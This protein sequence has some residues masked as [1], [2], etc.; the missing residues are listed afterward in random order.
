M[1]SQ[2]V[3]CVAEKLK[4]AALII[5]TALM[6]LAPSSLHAQDEPSTYT[7]RLAFVWG[8]LVTNDKIQASI[9]SAQLLTEAGETVPVEITSELLS[10]GGMAALQGALVEIQGQINAAGA[11][12]AHAIQRRV[13]VSGTDSTARTPIYGSH[14]WIVLLCQGAGAAVIHENPV[15]YYNELMGSQPYAVD[16]F[17]REV[18]YGKANV[19]GSRSA[20]WFDLPEPAAAYQDGPDYDRSLIADKAAIDCTRAADPSVDFTPYDGIVLIVPLPPVPDGPSA[21]WFFG[22]LA[23]L[24]LD[25]KYRVIRT[26]WMPM[27]IAGPDTRDGTDAH[28]IL[29]EMGHGF[30]LPHSSG[31]YGNVYDSKWD[32]MSMSGAGNCYPP[33]ETFK[34]GCPSQHTIAVHK[35]WLGWLD[36]D[37]LLT[38]AE[39][40][41]S[42]VLLNRLALPAKP[43]VLMIKAP[44]A[45]GTRYYTVEARQLSGYDKALATEAVIIHEINPSRKAQPAQVVDPDG[46]GDPN[47]EGAQWQPGERFDGEGGFTLCVKGRTPEGYIV[48]A[49]RKGPVNCTFKPDLSPSRYSTDM[50]YPTAGQTVTIEIELV[51]YQ[52]AGIQRRSHDHH[53][54]RNH[55][56]YRYG[57]DDSR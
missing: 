17:W 14:P 5:V 28:I 38:V 16:H 41:A 46:N 49:G 53:S 25:G 34:Y 32:M 21:T 7:G 48:A 56:Y 11:I 29:H 13:G 10:A 57:L 54:Q 24:K 19:L 42:E 33:D 30:G 43:G 55:L 22:G 40:S 12:Q 39:N 23:S 15:P 3:L 4:T 31:P 8:D 26:V 51:N 50:L 52:I 6:L 44:I 45:G 20:G 35:E 1:D 18:S 37:Q 47:D 36:A 9:M 2:D 27:E